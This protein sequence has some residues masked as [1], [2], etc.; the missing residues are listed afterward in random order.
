MGNYSGTN[1]IQIDVGQA[2][3]KMISFF[4]CSGMVTVFPECTL[5]ILSLVVFLP[6]SSRYQLKAFRDDITAPVIKDK[7]VNMV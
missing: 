6:G 1:H 2:F 7:Q 3:D 5:A 4:Y